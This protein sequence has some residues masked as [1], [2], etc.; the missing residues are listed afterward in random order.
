MPAPPAVPADKRIWQLYPAEHRHEKWHKLSRETIFSRV[1]FEHYDA[2]L[3]YNQVTFLGETRVH[4]YM[5]GAG[6]SGAATARHGRL[7]TTEA[8]AC[9]PSCTSAELF[10]AYTECACSF[11]AQHRLADDACSACTAFSANSH[12]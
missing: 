10:L 2:Q 9:T 8:W 12:C 11:F 7:L 3:Y 4:N 5:T 1:L 6:E